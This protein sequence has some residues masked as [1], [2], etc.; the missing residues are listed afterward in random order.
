MEKITVENFNNSLQKNILDRLVKSGATKYAIRKSNGMDSIEFQKCMEYHQ[1][2]WDLFRD[3]VLNKLSEEELILFFNYE[4]KR[5]ETY[6]QREDDDSK[7]IAMSSNDM[8]YQFADALRK[9][10]FDLDEEVE[11]LA[12]KIR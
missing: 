1:A 8:V 6:S 5:D 4:Y 11:D 10:S 12:S 3:E 2:L 7:N 9:G